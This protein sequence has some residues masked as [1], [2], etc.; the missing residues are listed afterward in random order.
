MPS[1]P[2]CARSQALIGSEPVIK[3]TRDGPAGKPPGVSFDASSPL[4]EGR[5]KQ[6][7]VR[8]MF[9]SIAPRYDL[10]NFLMTFG[11]D[12]PWRRRTI[13]LL[14]L[15]P[16]SV[17][18]DVGCGTGDLARSLRR[19]GQGAVGIDLS[20][21]MLAAARTGG[22]PLAQAD[23]VALPFRSASVD[24]VV[25]GFAVRNFADLPAVV[26]ELAR[27]PPR[28]EAFPARGG[29]A[30][31]RSFASRASGLGPLTSCL[32]WEPALS[33]GAAYRYLPRICRLPPLVSRLRGA[34]QRGRVQR[35]HPPQL[36]R[37]RRPVRDGHPLGA[38]AG[39][40]SQPRPPLFFATRPLEPGC[41]RP[42]AGKSPRERAGHRAGRAHGPRLWDRGGNRAHRRPRR[43]VEPR[44]GLEQLRAISALE[45]VRA[46]LDEDESVP[47]ALGALPFRPPCQ[48]EAVRAGA[49]RARPLRP[50]APSPCRRLERP[51]YRRAR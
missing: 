15:R 33:D 31:Q 51:G 6:A 38:R 28:R 50:P 7:L 8:S 9:D 11:L 35:S 22:A 27:A 45:D 46:D 3:T 36:Q 43:P 20:L 30:S 24:A 17:V 26:H 47:L 1:R 48:R 40:V 32:P 4:P 21:G 18:L 49:D 2:P 29:R 13:S 39:V 25:S 16:G 44:G 10:V 12:A 41:P 5:D 34:A 37:R 23:A 14:H 42:P 19:S